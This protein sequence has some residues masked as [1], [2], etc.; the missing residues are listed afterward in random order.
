MLGTTIAR[1]AK[2]RT[3]ATLGIALAAV[4]IVVWRVLVAI[5]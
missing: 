5:A 4:A 3:I 2:C 1:D